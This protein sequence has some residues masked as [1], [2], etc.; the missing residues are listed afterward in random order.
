LTLCRCKKKAN[1]NAD[2]CL[3]RGSQT[4]CSVSFV[5]IEQTNVTAYD[6]LSTLFAMI[7]QVLANRYVRTSP[8]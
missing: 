5:N 4:S 8:Y 6:W 3:S 7:I 2:A 1:K